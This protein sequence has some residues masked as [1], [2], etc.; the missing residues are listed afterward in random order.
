MSKDLRYIALPNTPLTMDVPKNKAFLII[1][2]SDLRCQNETTLL[3]SAT[4]LMAQ[5]AHHARTLKSQGPVNKN[6]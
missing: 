1:Q 2:L 4:P 3:D 6:V 5:R